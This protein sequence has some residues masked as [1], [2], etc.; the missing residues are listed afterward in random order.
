MDVITFYLM[1]IVV[2]IDMLILIIIQRQNL[3][4]IMHLV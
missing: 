4:V 3:R 2:M 1:H